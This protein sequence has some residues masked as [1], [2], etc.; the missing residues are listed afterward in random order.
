[1]ERESAVVEGL[2]A[3]AGQSPDSAEGTAVRAR[4]AA[5]LKRYEARAEQLGAIV[6]TTQAELRELRSVRRRLHAVRSVYRRKH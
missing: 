2:V 3:Q 4:V 1:I 5:L 6:A